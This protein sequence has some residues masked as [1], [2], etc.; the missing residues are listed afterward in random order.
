MLTQL[1]KFRAALVASVLLLGV[2]YAAPA[3]STTCDQYC[4]FDGVSPLD[5]CRLI[6]DGV[7]CVYE[8]EDKYPSFGGSC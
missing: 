1:R 2:G 4:P 3:A 6:L 8:D 5:D 7:E